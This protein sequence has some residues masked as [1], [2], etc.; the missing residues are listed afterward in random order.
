MGGLDSG[1]TLG[2][3]LLLAIVGSTTTPLNVA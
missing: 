3:L 2:S 1:M